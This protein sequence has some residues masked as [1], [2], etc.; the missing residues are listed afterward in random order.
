MKRALAIASAALLA[1]ACSS[2]P[3]S[4]TV[5]DKAYRD[6]NTTVSYVFNGK[7]TAPV[8]T[9]TPECHGLILENGEEVWEECV[10]ERTW[11]TTDVGDE[12]SKD[13]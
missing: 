4:G 9:S 1:A 13:D 2:N 6:A 3:D 8:I 11:L 5:I 10:S 7:T 12:W